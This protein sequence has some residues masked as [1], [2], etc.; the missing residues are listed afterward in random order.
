MCQL[1][2]DCEL[3]SQVGL[4][5]GILIVSILWHTVTKVSPK[6]ATQ[7]DRSLL[8]HLVEAANQNLAGRY[9]LY[10]SRRRHRSSGQWADREMSWA[11]KGDRGITRAPEIPLIRHQAL[12]LCELP[13]LLVP[14]DPAPSVKSVILRN[15]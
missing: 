4:T 3:V 12:H 9:A 1:P 10:Q 2:E 8:Q 5:V 15:N 6:Y 14:Y 7:I 13:T 11:L